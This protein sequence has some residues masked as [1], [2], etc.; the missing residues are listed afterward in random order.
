VTVD[1]HYLTIED[2]LELN[3]GISMRSV[4]E[5]QEAD[6]DSHPN[7][8]PPQRTRPPVQHRRGEARMLAAAAG[9]PDLPDLH[10]GYATTYKAR[11]TAA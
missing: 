2:L 11:H 1:I 8:L 7:L 9:E 6:L 10:P 5:K 3:H 4:N